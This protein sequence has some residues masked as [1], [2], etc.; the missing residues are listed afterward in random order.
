MYTEKK[1]RKPWRRDRKKNFYHVRDNFYPVRDDF[2]PVRDDFHPVRDDFHPAGD[3]F[4]P[5]RDFFYPVGDFFYPVRDN[6]HPVRDFCPHPGNPRQSEEAETL[7]QSTSHKH[8][9]KNSPHP[10]ARFRPESQPPEATSPHPSPAEEKTP[11]AGKTRNSPEK[12]I[13]QLPSSSSR[14]AQNVRY[15]NVQG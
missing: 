7:L 11:P 4:Y 2:H 5:V 12:Q 15:A 14:Y 3:F 8:P 1:I 13:K 10:A 6:F 9:P